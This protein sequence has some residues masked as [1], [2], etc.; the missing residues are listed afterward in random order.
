MQVPEDVA[1]ST[2]VV[3]KMIAKI[4]TYIEL[5]STAAFEDTTQFN[6]RKLRRGSSKGNA[7]KSYPTVWVVAFHAPQHTSH[8]PDQPALSS[9]LASCPTTM[10]SDLKLRMQVS[11][12]RTVDLHL[13]ADA[14]VGQLIRAAA[15]AL[16][17]DPATLAVSY[18][19][20]PFPIVWAP[21]PDAPDVPLGTLGV[22]ANS[23]MMVRL[24][25]ACQAAARKNH[26]SQASA[27]G[28]HDSDC[29]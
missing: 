25:D 19:V 17:A 27:E 10:A 3:N 4:G 16:H 1:N 18:K 23:V 24:V 21:L 2:S 13:P 20:K 9:T 26:A 7:E 29:R 22:S 12:G 11:D 6:L 5:G 8:H 14:T 15:D 28:H